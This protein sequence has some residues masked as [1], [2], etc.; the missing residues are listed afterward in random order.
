MESLTVGTRGSQLA[1]RQARWVAGL[2][3]RSGCRT[4]IRVIRTTGDRLGAVALAELGQR[5]GVK[6][7]FTKEIEDA[8]LAGA[9]DVAVHSLKDLPTELDDRLALGCVPTRADPRDALLGKGL[10][11]LRAG[12]RVGTGST[13]RAAQ[14]RALRPD[15]AVAGI[16]GNVDTRIRKLEAGEYDAIVLA[17]AGLERLGLQARVSEYLETSSMVPAAGQGALGIQVRAGDSRALDALAPLHDPRAA[18]EVAAER[19][20]LRSLGGGCD[21]PLGANAAARAGDL[22]L[23]AACARND[24]AIVRAEASGSPARAAALGSQVAARLLRLGAA[25]G[26]VRPPAP[27]APGG[28]GRPSR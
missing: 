7:V 19:E 2:L 13:R 4:G 16:R 6:G 18:A 5:E 15:L 26:G 9:I 14:L 25:C 17:A 1:L 12:D 8:L 22:L 3:E 20:L 23:V 10:D 27:S 21:V 11:G 24:G 28:S